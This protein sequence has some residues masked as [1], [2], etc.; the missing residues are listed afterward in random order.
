MTNKGADQ[1]KI[2][3]DHSSAGVRAEEVKQEMLSE[4]SAADGNQI[5]FVLFFHFL[6]FIIKEHP[7]KAEL[8]K[9]FQAR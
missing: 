9:E 2:R 8:F 4:S 1:V 7:P 5:F 3:T 6:L